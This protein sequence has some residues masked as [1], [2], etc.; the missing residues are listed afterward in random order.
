LFEF[1]VDG[2]DYPIQFAQGLVGQ[3]EAAVVEDIDLDSLKQS[4]TV[5]MLGDALDFEPL[6]TQMLG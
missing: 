3:I 4:N 1:V 2:S 6:F 5:Q